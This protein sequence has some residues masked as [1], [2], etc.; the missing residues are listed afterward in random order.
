MTREVEAVYENGMLR[1]LEPLPLE[2]HQRVTVMITEAD[3]S[4]SEL[5]RECIHI[6]T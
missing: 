1:P 3:T 2:E 5:W 6:R 4:S